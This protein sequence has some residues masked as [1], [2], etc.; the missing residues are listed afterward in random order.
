M[1]ENRSL[2]IRTSKSATQQKL[3]KITIARNTIIN[4]P[5]KNY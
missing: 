2:E 3:N 5:T 1:L 4:Y